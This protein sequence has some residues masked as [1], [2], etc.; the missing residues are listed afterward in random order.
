M[1]AQSDLVSIVIIS[2]II[3]AAGIT[4]WIFYSGYASVARLSAQ[5]EVNRELSILRSVISA[6]YV[7]CPQGEALLRNVG[8]EPVVIF[9]LIVYKN[10]ELVWDSL[11]IEGIKKL[12]E[13]DVGKRGG[14]RFT[15][16][17][18]HSKDDVIMLQVHYIPKSLFDPSLELVD[19]SSD[20]LLFKVANFKAEEVSLAL[21]GRTC[22]DEPKNWAWMDF[23]DPEEAP[24]YGELGQRIGIRLP[25]A[26][27]VFILDLKVSVEGVSSSASTT[28]S[29]TSKSDETQWISIDMSGM[30]YPVTITF[31]AI[32]PEDSNVLQREWYFD[33]IDTSYINYVQL[34]WNTLDKKLVGAYVS[35]FHRIS[36][37]YRVT[38]K[39]IDCFG[40]LVSDGSLVK[41]VNVSTN[42]AGRW[43]EYYVTFA[44]GEVMPNVRRIEVYVEDLSALVTETLTKY[45]TVNETV[46]ETLTHWVTQPTSTI[47]ETLT[48]T[49]TS[50]STRTISTVTQTISVTTTM[51]STRYLST[52]TVT[53]T[54]TR[55]TTTTSYSTVF[56]TTTVSTPNATQTVT[57]TSTAVTIIPT[58]TVS[59]TMTTTST[60][61]STPSPVT[62]TVT[63]TQTTTVATS[64]AST[65][66][67]VGT[68]VTS[69]TAQ[70]VT[71]TAC[72]TSS[73]QPPP[74]Y[75]A[76][77]ALFFA[78]AITAST[79]MRRCRR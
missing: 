39:V 66:T 52:V 62:S 35:A 15:C 18:S 21:A 25:D 77:A 10:G 11:R 19:P 6:D 9:R 46:T 45:V 38:V 79:I 67:T 2:A 69:I 5:N 61:I 34:I 73:S 32:S 48:I 14:V 58:T 22:P 50:I 55:S 59:Y 71:V 41:D 68:T 47:T 78:P 1:R 54:R 49:S 53:A 63:A 17:I 65:T 33:A 37:T 3:V 70:T 40:N 28:A 29:V 72:P 36:G 26:S 7:L 4:L 31:E 51:T 16:P 23:V 30:R 8:K 42:A 43:E 64:T 20:V 56:R 12:A 57:S 24:P 13:I 44:S 74:I 27:G 60:T 76:L 75:A